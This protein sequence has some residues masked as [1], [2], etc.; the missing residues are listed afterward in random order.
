MAGKKI[1]LIIALDGEKEFNTA[2]TACN[3]SIRQMNSEMKLVKEESKGQANTLETLQ[4]KHKILSDKLEEQRKKEAAVAAG[5]EHA[6][7]NYKS[8]GE[9]I[10]RYKAELIDA[11]AALNIMRESGTAS[12]EEMAA[13]EKAVQRLKDGIAEGKT[14]Y[15]KAGNS[16]K[17][18]ETKLNNAKAQ[19]IKANA[20]L[21]TN[22]AYM[23]EAQNC[24]GRLRQEY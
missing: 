12:A 14:I 22:A 18:W 23:K 8:I 2:V 21:E 3:K 15:E 13:Q 1:G 10:E 7:K 16:I 4:K 11:E 17:D 6:E 5:L 9:Q 19:T 20:E 24:C